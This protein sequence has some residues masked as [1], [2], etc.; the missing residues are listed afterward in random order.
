[1]VPVSTTV[2]TRHAGSTDPVREMNRW[3]V[4]CL[5]VV[6]SLGAFRQ[7]A[8]GENSPAEVLGLTRAALRRVITF[9]SLAFLEADRVARFPA[10]AVR[11]SETWDILQR[12]ID[13]KVAEG[14]FGWALGRNHQSSC[15]PSTRVEVSCSIR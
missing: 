13:A 9:E 8:A 12:D 10:D 7:D 15:R 5:D 4:E 14:V 3:L 11:P 2:A 1:M 6:V